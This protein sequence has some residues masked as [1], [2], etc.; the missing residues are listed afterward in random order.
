MDVLKR[1]T[2]SHRRG[3]V[4]RALGNTGAPA[5]LPALEEALKAETNPG[6]QGEMRGAIHRLKAKPA[7]NARH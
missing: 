7:V 6:A 2:D 1:E 3:Y 4:A 5:S